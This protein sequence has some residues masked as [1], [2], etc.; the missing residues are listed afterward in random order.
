MDNQT[1]CKNCEIIL[2]VGVLHLP[3]NEVVNNELIIQCIAKQ[4]LS[5][6][7]KGVN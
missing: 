2:D 5:W 6:I 4:L 1:Y 3:N 7:I